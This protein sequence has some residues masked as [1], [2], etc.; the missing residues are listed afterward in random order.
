[1]LKKS[2]QAGK[3]GPG[4]WC[5]SCSLQTTSLQPRSLEMWGGEKR[6]TFSSE[7]SL[8]P[9]SFPTIPTSQHHH[10][11]SLFPNNKADIQN[12]WLHGWV[13]RAAIF[14]TSQG[15]FYTNC[16]TRHRQRYCISKMEQ[17]IFVLHFIYWLTQLE[18]ISNWMF[19]SAKKSSSVPKLEEVQVVL[20]CSIWVLCQMS[21]Q[22][23]RTPWVPPSIFHTRSHGGQRPPRA[24]EWDFKHHLKMLLP[25][26]VAECSI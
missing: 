11:D 12:C 22:G 23:A 10:F 16:S 19:Y 15:R 20:S 25:S 21:K 6:E 1:M 26:Q 17:F 2:K 8:N 24:H 9:G 18:N 4:G 14:T 5:T 7:S 13:R 3:K